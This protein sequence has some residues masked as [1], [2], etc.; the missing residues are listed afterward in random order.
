MLYLYS[1]GSQVHLALANAINLFVRVKVLEGG[2]KIHNLTSPMVRAATEGH[3][4]VHDCAPTGGIADVHG[5]CC[6]QGP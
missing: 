2:K 3:V 5:L 1:Q 4:D 6:H